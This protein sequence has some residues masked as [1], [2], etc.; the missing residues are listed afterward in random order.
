TVGGFGVVAAI[1]SQ[2]TIALATNSSAERP[3]TDI[4]IRF[5]QAW[6][7]SSSSPSRVRA[8][9]S[10]GSSHFFPTVAKNATPDGTR[11]A[12]PHPGVKGAAVGGRRIWTS[13]LAATVTGCCRLAASSARR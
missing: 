3:R 8:E 7:E 13:G 10:R 12:G 4:D 9:V 2:R 11:I 1:T 6:D 5:F